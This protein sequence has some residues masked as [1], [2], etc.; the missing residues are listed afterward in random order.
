MTKQIN[1]GG[2]QQRY[3]LAARDRAGA[4]FTPLDFL[5]ELNCGTFHGSR[6]PELR[7]LT[8]RSIACEGQA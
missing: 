2:G 4:D 1:P 5:P 7:S 6:L 3:Q 8:D